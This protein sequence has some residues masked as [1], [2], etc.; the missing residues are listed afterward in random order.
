MRYR[1]LD[2]NGDY[3]FGNGRADYWHDVP[4]A[5][6]QA[7]R[8]RLSLWQGEWYLD[9]R[10]GMTWRTRVLGVRTGGTRDAAIRRHILGTEG[11]LSITAYSSAVQRD[12]RQFIVNTTIDTKYGP[13]QI[14][15]NS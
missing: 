7:V 5:P 13:F 1:K 6:A 15:S 2:E 9:N 10:E 11:V 14:G 3:T 4:E 12:P 8:T